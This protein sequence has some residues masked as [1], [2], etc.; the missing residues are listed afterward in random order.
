MPNFYDSS[1]KN[2]NENTVFEISIIGKV[3]NVK[4][5]NDEFLLKNEDLSEFQQLLGQEEVHFGITA[6]LKENTKIIINNLKIF[7]TSSI[8]E[9]SSPNC[10][11]LNYLSLKCVKNKIN[12]VI[13]ETFVDN[14]FNDLKNIS[15][16]TLL[17]EVVNEQKKDITTVLNNIKYQITSSFNQISKIYEDISTINLN[18][19][20]NKLKDL[21]IIDKNDIL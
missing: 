4:T 20:E 13:K 12:S 5:N 8:I 15:F 2:Y 11:I 18:P 7:E 10:N 14:L 3:L 17:E 16:S 21:N 9:N 6:G 1:S 19:C